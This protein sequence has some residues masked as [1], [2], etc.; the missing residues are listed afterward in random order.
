MEIFT[1]GMVWKTDGTGIDKYKTPDYFM[2]S[3]SVNNQPYDTLGV[4]MISAIA[5]DGTVN[6]ATENIEDS[7]WLH[8]DSVAGRNRRQ[9]GILGAKLPQRGHPR[10]K[11]VA[12]SKVRRLAELE[13]TIA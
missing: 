7:E 13:T 2:R 5:D 12:S 4:A 9:M 6:C 3:K 8:Y 10:Q 11:P 1:I